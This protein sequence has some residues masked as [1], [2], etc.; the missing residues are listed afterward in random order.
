MF[1]VK[2]EEQYS[3][4]ALFVKTAARGYGLASKVKSRAQKRR[5]IILSSADWLPHYHGSSRV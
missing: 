4:S 3:S 1:V 2:A 5:L